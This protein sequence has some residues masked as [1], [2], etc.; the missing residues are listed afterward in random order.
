MKKLI[1]N[2]I[3]AIK[4]DQAKEI[5][6]LEAKLTESLDEASK[7]E[8]FTD[9]PTHNIINIVF[10]SSIQDSH[11]AISIASRIIKG[12]SEKRPDE[13]PLLLSC[14]TFNEATLDECVSLVSSLTCCQICKRLGTLYNEF[15]TSQKDNPAIKKLQPV[16]P[17]EE[18]PVN[19]KN[20]FS[21]YLDYACRTGSLDNVK[22]LV[23]KGEDVNKEYTSGLP[24]KIAVENSKFKI[25]KYLVE[26]GAR[27]NNNETYTPLHIAISKENLQIVKYLIDNGAD[28]EAKETS[29]RTP[30]MHATDLGNFEIVKLLV[31]KG[32]NINETDSDGNT[33]LHIAGHRTYYFEEPKTKIYNFLVQNGADKEIIN[34]KGEKPLQPTKYK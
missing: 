25:I 6:Q 11:L 9:I 20:G 27:I 33:A 19:W 24:L 21:Y 8:S 1:S 7:E 12:I 29:E 22:Y 31:E 13:A 5:K 10:D 34:F 14:F 30:L 18:E 26:H 28:I 23:E 16:I 15:K 3:E 17:N 4:K 32:A 2:L